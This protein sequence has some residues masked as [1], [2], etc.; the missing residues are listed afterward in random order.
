MEQELFSGEFWDQYDTMF[1][2]FHN[3]TLKK[4][5]GSF[6]AGDFIECIN[7]DYENGTLELRKNFDDENTVT[8]RM[9]LEV[10]EAE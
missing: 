8:L 10:Y 5:I 4:D 3:C 1:F 9:R 2:S 7:V 6:K